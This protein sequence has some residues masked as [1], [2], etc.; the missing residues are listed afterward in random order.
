MTE[1]Y[2]YIT[3]D[4]DRWDLITYK[5]YKNPAL[6]EEIIKA[7]PEMKITPILDSGI[8]LKIPVLEES[9]TI[10]FETPPWKK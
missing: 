7:N 3:K 8:K 10:K 9:E 4:N 6:Y 1:Y 2:S 5:Y